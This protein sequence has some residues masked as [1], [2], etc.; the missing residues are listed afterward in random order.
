MSP[1]QR[2]R[3]RATQAQRRRVQL[4]RLLSP[5][6]VC[7]GCGRKFDNISELTVHHVDGKDWDESRMSQ[8]TRV[9]RYWREY[10]SGVRFS[11][12]CGTCNSRIGSPDGGNWKY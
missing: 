5:D 8:H 4:L 7:G 10:R 1:G 3:M 2:T 12:V 9:A 11:A 6:G